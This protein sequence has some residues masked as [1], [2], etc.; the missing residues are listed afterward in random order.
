[1]P[2]A[3]SHRPKLT[4]LAA[5]RPYRSE[6]TSLPTALPRAVAVRIP[7]LPRPAL[8]PARRQTPQRGCGRRTRGG[9]ARPRP[10]PP[11]PRNGQNAPLPQTH[12]C[13]CR[14]RRGNPQHLAKS[15][16]RAGGHSAGAEV[17]M[18]WKR[19]AR[20]LPGLAEPRPRSTRFV[21]RTGIFHVR[22]LIVII[23]IMIIIIIII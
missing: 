9:P 3:S 7:G 11:P 22:Y 13:A 19:R 6:S 8:R 17:T 20:Q 5:C 1:M 2:S 16:P 21:R 10:H 12:L 14:A 4:S 23:M 15:S 18:S